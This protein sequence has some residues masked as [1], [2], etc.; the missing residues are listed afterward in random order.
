MT[1]E[2]T[3]HH[4]LVASLPLVHGDGTAD[5]GVKLEKIPG[6]IKGRF[7]MNAPLSDSWEAFT[8]PHAGLGRFLHQL[9]VAVFSPTS[10][11]IGLA[12]KNQS[13]SDNP[14]FLAIERY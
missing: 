8:P 6:V 11:E 13:S 14:V 5:I 9:V 2:V 1:P 3:P 12:L 7:Y 4:G 10:M